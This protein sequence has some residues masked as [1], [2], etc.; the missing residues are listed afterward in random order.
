MRRFKAKKIRIPW[1]MTKKC[2]IV[3]ILV[4]VVLLHGLFGIISKRDAAYQ[5]LSIVKEEEATVISSFDSL[6]QEVIRLETPYG[7]EKTLRQIFGVTKPF[8]REIKIIQPVDSE[9]ELLP[10]EEKKSWWRNL[11]E[12]NPQ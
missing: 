10:L 2:I 12:N 7:E 4:F 3:E 9:I 8:E 1:Y 11:W 6:E 5:E